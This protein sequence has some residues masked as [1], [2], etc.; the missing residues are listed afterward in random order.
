MRAPRIDKIRA[1]AL[2]LADLSTLALRGVF[3]PVKTEAERLSSPYN[4]NQC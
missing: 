4:D 3:A 1:R 2:A